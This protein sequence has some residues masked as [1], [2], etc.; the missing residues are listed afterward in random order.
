MIQQDPG[1]QGDGLAPADGQGVDVHLPD[2]GEIDDHP[3]EADEDLLQL[4]HIGGG[5]PPEPLEHTVDARLLHEPPGQGL[6][7]GRQ[8]DGEI[9]EQLHADPP[10]AEEDD[11]A[12]VAVLLR[13]QDQLVVDVLDH[14]LHRDAPYGRLRG[15]LADPVE[16]AVIGGL[17][18]PLRN[19]SP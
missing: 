5:F 7:Q 9:Q 18:A 4:T 2:L 15:E 10:H 12:E 3:G 19:R 8:S 13:P 14:L 6:V 11:G 17:S 16:D 1:V